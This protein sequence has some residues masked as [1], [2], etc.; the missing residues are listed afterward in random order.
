MRNASWIC[1]SKKHSFKNLRKN[2]PYRKKE[3]HNFSKKCG[4]FPGGHLYKYLY[5]MIVCLQIDIAK[6]TLVND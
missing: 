5:T 2:V 1:V 4:L 3:E 6:K